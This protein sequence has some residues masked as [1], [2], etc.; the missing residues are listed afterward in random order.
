MRESVFNAELIS[1]LNHWGAWAY[2]IQDLPA[3]ITMGLRYVPEKPCDIIGAYRGKFFAIEGKQM[4]KFEAFG[5]RHMQ[6]SQIKHLN[7][8]VDTGSRGFVFLN[9][10]IGAVKGQTKR[11]NRLVIFDWKKFRDLGEVSLKQKEIMA[12]PY[13]SYETIDKK[14]IYNLSTFVGGL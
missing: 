10:R 5:M 2:K 8:I 6:S 9:I 12:L 7:K 13:V 3:S 1:S 11:V 14:I 4:K